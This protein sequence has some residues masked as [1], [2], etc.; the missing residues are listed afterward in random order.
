MPF[1]FVLSL[2][3]QLEGRFFPETRIHL[4]LPVLPYGLTMSA[5]LAQKRISLTVLPM[6]SV[7][8]T[9][10]MMKT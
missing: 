6:L 1:Y 2:W 10:T 8:Q 7:T 4:V 5:A 3:L 9:V